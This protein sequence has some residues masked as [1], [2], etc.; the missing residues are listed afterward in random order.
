MLEGVGLGE[1]VRVLGR[2][3]VGCNILCGKHAKYVPE[4]L[5]QSSVSR[6]RAGTPCRA[7]YTLWVRSAATWNRLNS[8]VAEMAMS[9]SLWTNESSAPGLHQSQPTWRVSASASASVSRVRIRSPLTLSR[10][11]VT[12]SPSSS[13]G[14]TATATATG[15]G[16]GPPVTTSLL[17]C[18]LS[19]PCL[20]SLLDCLLLG[21]D[22]K[23]LN[24]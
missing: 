21:K 3:G 16:L 15:T 2:S 11:M 14:S 6:V 4:H 23:M 17:D 22:F 19:S 24:N 5:L 1:V 10:L 7:R 18:L 13:R 20:R 8:A 9:L 12:L